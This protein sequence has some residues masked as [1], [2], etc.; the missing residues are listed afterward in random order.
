KDLAPDL[1]GEALRGRGVE[2]AGVDRGGTPGPEPAGTVDP[3]ARHAGRVPDDRLAAADQP[4]EERGLPD[5]RSAND[6]DGR[7]PHDAFTH[8][9][10]GGRR[11]GPRRSPP[12]SRW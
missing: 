4:V 8:A 10:P 12:A 5:V 1:G 3:I 11:G 2:P 7:R 9:G 6:R